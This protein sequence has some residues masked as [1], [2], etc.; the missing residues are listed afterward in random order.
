M[1][2]LFHVI[3][4]E[5]ISIILILFQFFFQV[6]FSTTNNHIAPSFFNTRR[7]I[8]VTISEKKIPWFIFFFIFCIF[9]T[10]KHSNARDKKI[11]RGKILS[12]P[13]DNDDVGCRERNLQFAYLRTCHIVVVLHLICLYFLMLSLRWWWRKKCLNNLQQTES[14]FLPMENYRLIVVHRTKLK[15]FIPV[16]L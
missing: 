8:S 4:K 9:Y 2:H 1:K 11:S 13:C 12:Q 7:N 16:T 14:N 3:N 5:K 10:G 6:I 15:I